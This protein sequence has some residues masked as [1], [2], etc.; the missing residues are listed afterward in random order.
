VDICSYTFFSLVTEWWDKAVYWLML[1]RTDIRT[2]VI[3]KYRAVFIEIL[4]SR[5]IARIVIQH[6]AVLP[7]AANS[8]AVVVRGNCIRKAVHTKT[9][10]IL[11]K[12]SLRLPHRQICMYLFTS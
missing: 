6:I 12:T 8:M 1:L 3:V 11:T 7:L 5:L 10:L 9:E 4:F 2:F